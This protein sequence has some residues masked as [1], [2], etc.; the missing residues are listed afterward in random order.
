[1]QSRVKALDKIE[2]IKSVKDNPSMSFRFMQSGRIGAIPVELLGAVAGYGD[3]LVYNGIDFILQRGDRVCLVGPNG[4]GKSTLIKILAEALPL[5]EGKLKFGGNVDRAFFAQHQLEALN[6]DNSAIDE[7]TNN[8]PFD[9]I[10]KVRGAMAALGLREDDIDKKVK[11][12]SG[13]E[14]SRVALTKVAL[15]PTNLLLLDE[16]TNHLDIKSRQALEEALANYGGAIVFITHDRAFID[17]VATKI[18]HVENGRLTEYLGDYEYYEKKRTE[19]NQTANNSDVKPA[20]TAPANRKEARRESAQ[21]RAAQSKLTTPIKRKIE[22]LETGIANSEQ[23]IEK[24]E[25]LLTDPLMYQEK[26]AVV[27]YSQA[28]AVARKEHDKQLAEW[29]ELSEQLERLTT[30]DGTERLS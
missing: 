23:E 1:M 14:K 29:T 25:T 21:R 11:V 16:P 5:I 4:A 24:Y 20:V 6:P 19:S 26:G 7:I 28:L 10:P 30:Q 22:A 9:S 27:E 8:I 17:A 18:V 2:R 3:K 15:T 12:L 13:G